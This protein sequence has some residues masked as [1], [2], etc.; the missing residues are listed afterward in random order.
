[1][2]NMDVTLNKDILE[3]AKLARKALNNCGLCP[4]DCGVDRTSGEKGYCQL[5]DTVRCFREMLYYGEESEIAPSHQIHLAGCNL[6]CVYCLVAQ[7][8]G[9]PF[10]AGKIDYDDIAKK[11]TFRQSQ[12]A[13]TLSF[14][15]GE[16]SVNLHGVL[17]LLGRVNSKFKVVWNSNMYYNDLVHELITGI[18]DVYL[19]DFKCGNNECARVLLGADNYIEIVKKNILKAARHADV[20]VRH[21]LIPGHKKC[22]LEPILQWLATEIPDVK[23]SLRNNYVPPAQ[24]AAA[25]MTYLKPE[26]FQNAVGMA[27]NIG[28]KLIK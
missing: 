26:E 11:I 4:R 9:Q 15:G 23:L 17:E 5:D 20:I 18:V 12:G 22:C 7:W 10:A 19:A 6:K 14:L 3:R 24:A 25:P 27:K 21:V 8:N 16:P 1:M 28:L 2:N 13:K